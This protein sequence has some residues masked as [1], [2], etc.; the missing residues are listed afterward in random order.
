MIQHPGIDLVDGRLI[1]GTFLNGN[2]K[3]SVAS[4][5]KRDVWCKDIRTKEALR[6]LVIPL[7]QKDIDAGLYAYRLKLDIGSIW[8]NVL[9][10]NI[11][12]EYCTWSLSK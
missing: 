7:G 12:A 11:Y 3:G 8:Y 2:R 9:N 1:T 6:V 4:C 5:I 10:G